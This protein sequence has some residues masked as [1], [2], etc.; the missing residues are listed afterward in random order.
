[1]ELDVFLQLLFGILATLIALV[2]IWIKRKAFRREFS[3]KILIEILDVLSRNFARVNEQRL[4][5]N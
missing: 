2:G 1:M 5:R 4:T 3:S